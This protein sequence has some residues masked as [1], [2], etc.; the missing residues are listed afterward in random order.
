MGPQGTGG[1][2]IKEGVSIRPLMVG[3]SGVHSYSKTHPSELPTA[4]EAGTLNSHGIAGLHA[5]LT[6][7]KDQGTE[8]LYEKEYLLMR[9]FYEG[10]RTIPSVKVYGD[11]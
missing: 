8:K 11:F 1:L 5:A 9:T 7:L 3:G 10:V 2:L 6:Y 4:L